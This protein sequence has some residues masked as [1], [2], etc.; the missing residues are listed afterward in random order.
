MYHH[1]VILLQL[2]LFSSLNAEDW[3]AK[4]LSTPL[5]F[6]EE[7][8]LKAKDESRQEHAEKCKNIKASGIEEYPYHAMINMICVE[9]T[10]GKNHTI[11]IPSIHGFIIAQNYILGDPDMFLARLFRE[12]GVNCDYSVEFLKDHSVHKAELVQSGWLSLFKLQDSNDG[13]SQIQSVK[14]VEA[15][16][17]PKPGDNVTIVVLFNDTAGNFGVKKIEN[18]TLTGLDR[19]S[20]FMDDKAVPNE[21]C[22]KSLWIDFNE[23]DCEE[24]WI[25]PSLFIKDQ[26]VGIGPRFLYEYYKRRSFGFLSV[27]QKRGT[28]KERTAI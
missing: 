5:S 19:C 14:L 13:K 9:E 24:L 26:L 18:I 25:Q 17:E 23:Q 6:Y 20:A 1:L 8:F 16:E 3:S 12:S 28:I 7:M 10:D 27:A 21:E 15:G 4:S 11:H 2:L 22:L